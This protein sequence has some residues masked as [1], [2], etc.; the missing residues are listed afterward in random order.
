MAGLLVEGFPPCLI[1]MAYSCHQMFALQLYGAV[2]DNF[3]FVFLQ[4]W[5]EARAGA[6]QLAA[7]H[8]HPTAMLLCQTGELS[9]SICA[10]S[11]LVCDLSNS[12]ILGARA[13]HI[14][15]RALYCVQEWLGRHICSSCR[16]I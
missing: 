5:A 2:L 10:S 14:M 9:L 12:S 1:C 4:V 7:I 3:L 8:P 16:Y 13:F 11:L 15:F 6:S